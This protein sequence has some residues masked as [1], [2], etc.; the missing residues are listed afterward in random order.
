[1][2]I[3]V[4]IPL[5]LT[6]IWILSAIPSDAA[7]TIPGTGN[8][9]PGESFLSSADLIPPVGGSI[10]LS[11]SSVICRG[12]LLAD[13]I[14]DSLL[15]LEFDCDEVVSQQLMIN[16]CFY[17]FNIYRLGSP[18]A[19]YGLYSLRRPAGA[20][21]SGYLPYGALIKNRGLAVCDRFLFE[22]TA[23]RITPD[24]TSAE[25]DS[26]IESLMH[27]SIGRLSAA[28]RNNLI[29]R[30]DP[31]CRL[32]LNGRLPGSELLAR[33]PVSLHL[34][35]DNYSSRPIGKAVDA[36]QIALA[37]ST[38]QIGHIDPSPV[39]EPWWVLA[40][41]H[42]RVDHNQQLKP[43]TLVVQVILSDTA[44]IPS[45]HALL[46]AARDGLLE[47]IDESLL[48]TLS[49]GYFWS[50][51]PACHGCLIRRGGELLFASSTLPYDSFKNWATNLSTQQ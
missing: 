26:T 22:V 32:P 24:R 5:I 37:K 19:A 49:R 7:P 40:G 8:A 3:K 29:T 11:G 48:H 16:Q 44:G 43:A 45:A 50:L 10:E 9:E 12:D 30:H 2:A 1:M 23:E 34:A 17:L 42:P 18:L 13:C 38:L 14:P 51:S 27:S 21:P 47:T 25:V 20:G 35:L 31:F 33:G 39:S 6:L 28:Q 15:F 46:A 4:K 41:Y 36:V